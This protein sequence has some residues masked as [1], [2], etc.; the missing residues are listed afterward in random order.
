MHEVDDRISMH[1]ATLIPASR[2]QD[3][4]YNNAYHILKTNTSSPR[5]SHSS[6]TRGHLDFHATY[7]TPRIRYRT[8][9]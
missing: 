8:P 9:R 7:I 1:I 6:S 2:S 5:D 3:Q 4:V